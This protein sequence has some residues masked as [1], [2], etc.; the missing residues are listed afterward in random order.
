MKKSK[1]VIMLFITI[2]GML[3]L[4]WNVQSTDNAFSIDNPT[5]GIMRYRYEE[6]WKWNPN[7]MQYILSL[8]VLFFIFLFI[9]Y[10]LISEWGNQDSLLKNREEKHGRD[11]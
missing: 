7:P 5:A 4:Y 3:S 11:N 1:I 6:S 2:C 9:I 10:G 8:G